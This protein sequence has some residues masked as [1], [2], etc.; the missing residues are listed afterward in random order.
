VPAP[1]DLDVLVIDDDEQI[2][3]LIQM[4][5]GQ[6]RVTCAADGEAGLEAFADGTWDVIL[7]DLTMPGANGLEV[8]A[9]VHMQDPDVPLVLMTGW[10]R[11]AKESTSDFVAVLQKPFSLGDLKR[12]LKR[13]VG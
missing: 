7:V 8:G 9:E 5:L 4:A 2:L 11:P 6:C 1:R 10:K 3:S 13:V 12:C